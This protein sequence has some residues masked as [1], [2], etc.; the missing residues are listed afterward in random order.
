MRKYNLRCGYCGSDHNVRYFFLMLRLLVWG[1]V[2]VKCSNCSNVSAYIFVGHIVHDTVDG[3][4]KELNRNLNKAKRE[5]YR[6]G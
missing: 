3:K 4:E 1:K 2:Y 5:L 6:N